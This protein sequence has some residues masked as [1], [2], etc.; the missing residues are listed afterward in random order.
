[1]NKIIKY[2][3]QNTFQII[4]I[5]CFIIFVLFLTRAAE[6]SYKVDTNNTQKQT[7]T[8]KENKK[9]VSSKE[10]ENILKEFLESATS[11]DYEK[12]Y[13]YLSPKCKENLY[14]DLESFVENYCKNF[15]I[16]GKDYSIEK[17]K[18]IS[19]NTYQVTFNNYLSSGKKETRSQLDLITVDIEDETKIVLNINGYLDTKFISKKDEDENIKVAIK[20]ANKYA[21]YT[22][23]EINTENKSDEMVTIENVSI[24]DED[25]KEYKSVG[26]EIKIEANN[27]STN[28]YRFYNLNNSETINSIYINYHFNDSETKQIHIE[29]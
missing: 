27:E 6:D 14:T 9:S 20:K 21:G 25:K 24:F 12:A 1:M 17:S 26:E 4:L 18:N 3:R 8:Q 7:V 29:I 16:K 10:S 13:T 28:K 15:N 11:G 23:I 22:E 5:I 19:T 2:L